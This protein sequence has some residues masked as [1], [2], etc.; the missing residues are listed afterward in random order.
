MNI[1]NKTDNFLSAP[2]Q[3]AINPSTEALNLVIGHYGY[4][5]TT[6]DKKTVY[7]SEYHTFRLHYIFKGSVF[8]TKNGK[9]K[10]LTA[11][12]CFMLSPPLDSHYR[13]NPDDPAILFWIS[14]SGLH[15]TRITNAIGFD[16]KSNGYIKLKSNYKNR[17]FSYM[18]DNFRPIKEDFLPLVLLKN[19]TKITELLVDSTLMETS[20]RDISSTDML[21]AKAIKYI[22]TNYT[23]PYL[24]ITDVAKHVYVHE[25]YLSSIFKEKLG[26][27]F[28]Q[29]VTQQRMEQAVVLLKNTNLPIHTISEM[30]GYADALYFS[31]VFKKFNYL[32]PQQSRKKE[33]TAK[34]S[35]PP[36]RNANKRRNITK[37]EAHDPKNP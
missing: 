15:A 22:H 12:T 31:K 27:T 5:Q 7:S 19:F 10:K 9:E 14:Y 37:H 11:N 32:S 28:T 33:K 3:T 8:Y 23:N 17:M 13:T 26:I 30:V 34:I 35:T 1:K 18:R 24:T 20:K 21:I 2:R 29:Y 4:E 25:N 16:E 6:P 36:H